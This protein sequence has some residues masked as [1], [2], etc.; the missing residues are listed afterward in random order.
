MF[1]DDWDQLGWCRC[2]ATALTGRPADAAWRALTLSRGLLGADV[3]D[4]E[5]LVKLQRQMMTDILDTQRGILNMVGPPRR[6]RGA[7]EETQAIR[8]MDKTSAPRTTCSAR[9][10][11]PA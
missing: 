7:E 8:F 3:R 11:R 6:I 2:H 10:S 4:A 1:G 9:R 5:K